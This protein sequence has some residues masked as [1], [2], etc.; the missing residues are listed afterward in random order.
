MLITPI[1]NFSLYISFQK[2][3][4]KTNGGFPDKTDSRVRL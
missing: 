2:I 4:N 3:K 1:K